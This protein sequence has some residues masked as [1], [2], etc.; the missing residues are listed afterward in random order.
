MQGKRGLAV[1]VSGEVLRHGGGNRLVARHDAFH[2]TAHGF[3][4]QRKR[5]HIQQQQIAGRVVTGQL[6]GLNGST[7]GDDFVR[8]E[9]GERRLVKKL[10]HRYANLRHAGRAADQHHALDIFPGQTCVA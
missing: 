1:L 10:V 5:N 8:V 4:P 9:V 7:E 6:V 3:H 2:Q